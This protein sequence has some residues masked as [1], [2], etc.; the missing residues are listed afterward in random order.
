MG[1][2]EHSDSGRHGDVGLLCADDVAG[3]LR[4]SPRTVRRLAGSGRMPRPLKVGRL[5]R[6]RRA[7]MDEWIARGCPVCCTRG[8]RGVT[9]RAPAEEQAR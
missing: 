5:V 4:C 7:D 9:Q 6:W 2:S 1:D 3:M 8:R